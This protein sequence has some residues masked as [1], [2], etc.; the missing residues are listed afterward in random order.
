[1]AGKKL[2]QEYAI[3]SAFATALN[4]TEAAK[5]VG[6]HSSNVSRGIQR[7]EEQ[8][9]IC[10]LEH[11][12]HGVVLT[13][14]GERL[15]D[16]LKPLLGQL[17]EAVD[18]ITSSELNVGNIRVL[19]PQEALTQLVN[20][21]IQAML[22]A[23][24]GISFE[25]EATTHLPDPLEN[26]FDI[27]ISHRR[28]EITDTALIVKRL[29]PYRVG[30]FCAPKLLDSHPL[31]STPQ[32][33]TQWPCLVRQHETSWSLINHDKKTTVDIP[34]HIKVSA[35]P[36]TV[37]MDLARSGYGITP[38]SIVLC[39]PYVR[40]GSLV[41]VLPDYTFR[42]EV[43]FVVQKS[44]RLIRPIVTRFIQKLHEYAESAERI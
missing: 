28:H 43:L 35:T 42:D 29:C 1:M 10:L 32:E 26:D 5:I 36:Q 38:A 25:M 41:R 4:Y 23:E 19:G 12:P 6:M 37:R 2:Y 15:A 44:H 9:G 18:V 33:L 34:L 16:A 11:S 13:A 20:P 3:F 21:V 22:S 27:F 17:D 14:V 7:L 24:P 31:P 40:D 30:L 8:L 39:A